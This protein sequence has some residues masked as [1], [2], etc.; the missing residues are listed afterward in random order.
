MQDQT[1][2]MPHGLFGSPGE[3][4]MQFPMLHGGST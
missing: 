3:C 2:A 1:P 4:I